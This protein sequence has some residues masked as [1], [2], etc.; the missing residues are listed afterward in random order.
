MSVSKEL[1][2]VQRLKLKYKSIPIG[3]ADDTEKRRKNFS[4]RKVENSLYLLM[5]MMDDST[6]LQEEQIQNRNMERSENELVLAYLP[7]SQSTLMTKCA[8]KQILGNWL[9]IFLNFLEIYSFD[10]EFIMEVDL[11]EQKHSCIIPFEGSKEKQLM[12]SMNVGH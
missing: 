2:V 6:T 4:R 11:N 12:N 5:I 10:V 7:R 8:A 9:E 1:N 3:C